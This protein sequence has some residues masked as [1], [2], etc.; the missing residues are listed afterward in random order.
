MLYPIELQAQF[1]PHHDGPGSTSVGRPASGG[2]RFFSPRSLADQPAGVVTWNEVEAEPDPA[3]R[4]SP[5]PGEVPRTVI[6]TR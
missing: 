3:G 6:D 4:L 1:C 5:D 2:T